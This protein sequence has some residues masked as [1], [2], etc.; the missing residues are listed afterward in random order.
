[1]SSTPITRPMLTRQQAREHYDRRGRRPKGPARFERKAIERLIEVGDFGLAESVVEF[2]CGDGSLAQR[3]MEK[4][5]PMKATYAA[6]DVSDTM[7]Q[8]T[9]K[10]M[11]PFGS[12]VSVTKTDVSALIVTPSNAP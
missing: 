1:M 9:R 6:F 5:L 7:V 12:R 4:E 11:V 3:L 2:G 10:R 8:A